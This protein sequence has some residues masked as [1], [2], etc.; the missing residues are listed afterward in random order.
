MRLKGELLLLRGW[1][2]DD[3]EAQVCFGQALHAARRQEAKMWEL[4]AATSL[5]RVWQR[6]GRRE[7]PR[8]LLAGVYEWFT[9]GLDTAD[10]RD[11]RALLTEL[12][13]AGGA[14]RPDLVQTYG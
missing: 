11:A 12:S 3:A 9:E 2:P 14:E 4:R 6:Q 7:E 8:A 10:L 5:A 13:G 1:L